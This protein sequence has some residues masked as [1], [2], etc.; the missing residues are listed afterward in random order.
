MPKRQ[1]AKNW[2]D[3]HQQ[4][5]VDSHT[6]F[7]HIE[8]TREDKNTYLQKTR[9]VVR[10]GNLPYSFGEKKRVNGAEP[11]IVII[12]LPCISEF[13][14][15]KRIC[16]CHSIC[17]WSKISNKNKTSAQKFNGE[18]FNRYKPNHHHEKYY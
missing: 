4:A 15:T 12:A 6:G 13:G 17:C 7:K 18:E 5:K 9:L 16:G 1:N 3:T 14:K 10:I 8:Y 11:I 2:A